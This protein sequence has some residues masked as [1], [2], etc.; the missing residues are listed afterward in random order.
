VRL[1]DGDAE[2]LPLGDDV[3]GDT[4]VALAGAPR[5]WRNALTGAAHSPGAAPQAALADVLADFPVALLLAA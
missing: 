5:R 4:G 2:G 1:L 3:F